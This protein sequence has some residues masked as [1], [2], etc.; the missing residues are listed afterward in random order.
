M[1]APATPT[2][3]RLAFGE[4]AEL[5]D[6]SR[7][8]YPSKLIDDV[9][10]LAQIGPAPGDAPGRHRQILE[11]GAGTGKATTLFASRGVGVLAIEPSEQMAAV[12]RRNC[13]SFPEVE[14]VETDFECWDPAG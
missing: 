14:I 3:R 10:T 11:V 13:A 9:L 1:E 8:S 6:A 7:P 5:Y 4:V 12:A 2:P